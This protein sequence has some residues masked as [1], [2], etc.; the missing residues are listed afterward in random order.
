MALLNKHK[1]NQFRASMLMKWSRPGAGGSADTGGAGAVGGGGFTP[2]TMAKKQAELKQCQA[3]KK[4]L[5]S[6]LRDC[7]D[8]LEQIEL[9][10]SRLAEAADEDPDIGDALEELREQLNESKREKLAELQA[11]EQMERR[12]TAELGLAAANDG[13]SGEPAVP[14]AA[15]S[16]V[17]GGGGAA[18]LDAATSQF[19]KAAAGLWKK[20]EASAAS[21]PTVSLLS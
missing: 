21:P 1:T 18:S 12:L 15:A 16:A 13:S 17:E 7:D 8:Q 10:K 2:R 19:V 3:D 9:E 14:T 6:E 11:V 20:L 5:L 4:A